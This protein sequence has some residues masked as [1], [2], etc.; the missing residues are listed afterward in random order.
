[1]IALMFLFA[2]VWFGINFATQMVE[3]IGMLIAAAERV[4]GGDLAARVLEG[5]G[6][7]EFASL[8]RA[9]NRMTT[10]LQNQQSELIEANHQLDQRSRFTEA[11][12]AGV[13]AGIIGL[14]PVGRLNLTNRSASLL[15]A[16]ELDHFIGQDLADVVP[17]MAEPFDTASRRPNRLAQ[18]H[19]EI[20]RRG[21]NQPQCACRRHT[22]QRRPPRLRLDPGQRVALPPGEPERDRDDDK[23]M[24]EGLRAHPYRDYRRRGLP[25]QR[26]Q[27][28]RKKRNRADRQRMVRKA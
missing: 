7:E 22:D 12:L 16:T 6:D 19:I 28:A 21:R 20:V 14:D 17:E 10:Q 23:P 5:S 4:R 25:V 13:S 15:L 1:M 2:A 24:R 26:Q 8:S 9:F 18:S 11:V 27:R 3:P